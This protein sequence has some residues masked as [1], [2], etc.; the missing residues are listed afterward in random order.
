MERESERGGS[1]WRRMEREGVGKRRM[2]TANFSGVVVSPARAVM[3]WLL[4]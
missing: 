1:I 3:L 4:Y 2:D